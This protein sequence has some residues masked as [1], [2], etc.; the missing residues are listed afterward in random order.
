MIYQIVLNESVTDSGIEIVYEHPSRVF[1]S[2]IAS[3][4]EAERPGRSDPCSPV[5]MRK[6]DEI[7]MINNAKVQDLNLQTFNDYLNQTPLVL[8]LR[9]ARLISERLNLLSTREII[10]K[11]NSKRAQSSSKVEPFSPLVSTTS[12]ALP[13]TKESLSL[14][15]RIDKVTSEFMDTERAYVRVSQSIKSVDRSWNHPSL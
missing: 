13:L 5:E 6:G 11:Q 3:V 2:Q 4:G 12:L 10:S 9:S 8:V 7:V 15:Q 14:E 1:V